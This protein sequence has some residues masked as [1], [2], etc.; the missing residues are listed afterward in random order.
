ME[1]VKD[2][3]FSV[4]LVV[5]GFIGKYLFNKT[6]RRLES[7]EERTII[8]EK[9]IAIN[10][11]SDREYREHTQETLREIKEDVKTLISKS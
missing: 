8:N 3:I 10:H 1:D 2:Y 7:L 6:E 5:L 9:E 11:Q 4:A